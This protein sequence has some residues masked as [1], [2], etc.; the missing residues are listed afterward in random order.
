MKV[1]GVER[2]MTKEGALL[3]HREMWEDMQKELGDCPTAADRIAY[4]EKWLE[5]HGYTGV[6]YNCFLCEYAINNDYSGNHCVLCPIDWSPLSANRSNYCT[7]LY[8]RNKSCHK[9]IY[10][11]AKISEILAL[12]ER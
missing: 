10:G 3:L 5:K 1:D 7:S 2:N 6:L 9:N 8:W 12:P 4:K 11:N